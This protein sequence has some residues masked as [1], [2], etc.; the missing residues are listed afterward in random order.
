[1]TR[2][3]IVILLLCCSGVYGQKGLPSKTPTEAIVHTTY[4]KH[5]DFQEKLT[6]Q[7]KVPDG[8]VLKVAA[9]G[10]GKPRMIVATQAGIYVTRRDQGDILFLSDTNHDGRMD[11]LITVWAKFRDV[12]GIAIKDNWLYACSDKELKKA[13]IMSDNQLAD[14]STILDNLPEG[15]QHDNR[16]IGFGP[17]G[18]L[19]M[20]VGSS[21]N[22][23]KETNPEHATILQMRPDGSGRKIFARG[24][25]NTIGFDW[26][27]DTKELW[28]CDNGTDWRGDSIPPEE[29]NRIID[30][31]NY[32]WPQV[33]GKQQVDHTREDPMGTTK[34]AYAKT[35]IPSVMEFPAHSAPIDFKFLPNGDAL[36]CWHGSWN[37]EH[38]EGYKVQQIHFKDGQPTSVSDFFSGFL[39]KQGE[40]R[41]GRPAGLAVD[42]K[43]SIFIT[44]DENGVIYTVSPK[45]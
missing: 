14:T 7:L 34:E 44:D 20:S 33:F 5:V 39:S 27:P 43:G 32:G 17:D 9:T 28:G 30:S 40:T 16:V 36:V 38:P 2:I 10:L 37:R 18:M 26:Q 22:D 29:L 25:R 12:H 35:T 8:Y 42:S 11:R 24:L 3:F 13:R 6:A 31:G 1:M 4:P 21:C 15:S 19:Y 41:F 23:C 45:K